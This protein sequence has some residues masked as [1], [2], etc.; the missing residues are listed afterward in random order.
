MNSTTSIKSEKSDG[1]VTRSMDKSESAA[2]AAKPGKEVLFK[3]IDSSKYTEIRSE[4]QDNT[5]EAKA[6]FG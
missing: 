2:A 5:F 6:K 4:F 3:R 1:P